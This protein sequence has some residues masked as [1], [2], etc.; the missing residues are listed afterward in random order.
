MDGHVAAAVE[1]RLTQR[2]RHDLTAGED[3]RIAA[4]VTD[5][6]ELVPLVDAGAY[7]V[8]RDLRGL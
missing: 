6:N 4:V 2:V 3:R 7:E 8:L 1:Q 5:L